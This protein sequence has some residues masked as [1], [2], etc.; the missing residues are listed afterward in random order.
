M[1]FENEGW[2]VAEAGDGEVGLMR[3]AENPPAAIVLDLNMPRMNGIE[4]LEQFKKT[5]EWQSIP[6]LAL[7]GSMVDDDVRQNLLASI[8]MVVEKGPYSLD[9]L[10]RRLRELI[11]PVKAEAVS[12]L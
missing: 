7:T 8:D 1:V 9:T 4:F 6:V 2:I 12:G 3:L 11:G 5:T 10:L